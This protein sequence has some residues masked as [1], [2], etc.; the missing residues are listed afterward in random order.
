MRLTSEKQIPRKIQ[1]C[2]HA[3]QLGI[4][5]IVYDPRGSSRLSL[6][7][8]PLAFI[9]SALIVGAYVTFYDQIFSWWPL[10]QSWM[11]LGIGLAWFLIGLWM[12]VPA[13]LIPSL[14]VFLCPKGLI[15]QRYSCDV[16]RWQDIVQLEKTLKVDHGSL[17]LAYY[18]LLRSDGTAFMLDSDLPHLDRLGGFMERE[19]SRYLL[20]QALAKYEAESSLAFG[21]L[22]VSPMGLSLQQGRYRLPWSEYERLSLD[23][24]TLS[25]YGYGDSQPW[26]ALSLSGLPNVW[27]LKGIIEHA[28]KQARVPLAESSPILS[29]YPQSPQLALYAAGETLSFGALA[30]NRTGVFLNDAARFLPWDQIASFGIGEHDIIIKCGDTHQE[31]YTLPLW[32]ITNPPLLALITDYALFQQYL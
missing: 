30:L 6:F 11:V 2:A 27:V 1:A 25:I 29:Q 24:T 23:D 31:L 15:Y 17:S 28:T 4:P 20:P 18:R 12:L 10:W 26:V 3:Y 19:V 14:R 22:E 13:L 32:T 5:R 9:V 21:Q 16:I 7:L 8:S